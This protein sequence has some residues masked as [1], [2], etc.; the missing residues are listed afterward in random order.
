MVTDHAIELRGVVRYG[1]DLKE[2]LIAP[3]ARNLVSRESHL[4]DDAR[5]PINERLVDCRRQRFLKR[6]REGRSRFNSDKRIVLGKQQ[7]DS[8]LAVTGVDDLAQARLTATRK[9]PLNNLL[10]RAVV[11]PVRRE[12]APEASQHIARLW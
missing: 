7:F 3:R 9:T 6:G 12:R 5:A 11:H 2:V 10:Q 8:M 1:R 4:S